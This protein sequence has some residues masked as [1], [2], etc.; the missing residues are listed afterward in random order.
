M[1]LTLP[2]PLKRREILYGPNTPPGVLLDYGRAY[3]EAG[4]PTDALQFYVQA[5]D[6]DGL[7]RVKATAVKNGDAFTMKA[8]A[9]AMPDLVGESDWRT[10]IDRAG[11]LGK[12]LFAAQAKAALEGQLGALEPEEKSG[13]GKD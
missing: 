4:R 3:E 12:E 6:R 13:Q 5:G 1:G 10:L 7:D 2:E 9:R 11:Q 8:V